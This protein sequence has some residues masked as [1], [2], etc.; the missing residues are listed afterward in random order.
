MILR[1]L[2]ELSDPK[3]NTGYPVCLKRKDRI[4]EKTK[5]FPLNKTCLALDESP[6]PGTGSV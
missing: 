6:D 2:K 4:D 3:K 5:G 1:A